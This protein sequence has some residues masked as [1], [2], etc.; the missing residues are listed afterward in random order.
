MFLLAGS[1][2][3]FTC[4][5][6]LIAKCYICVVYT[7]YGYL[8]CVS[9][10]HT[11]VNMTNINCYLPVDLLATADINFSFSSNTIYIHHVYNFDQLNK[12]WKH[13]VIRLIK[14]KL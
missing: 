12:A 7:S 6:D 5:K 13:V 1:H 2:S 11:V 9:D 3:D 10:Q 4:A 14:Y 8:D